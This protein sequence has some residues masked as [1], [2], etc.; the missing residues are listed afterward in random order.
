MSVETEPL[1]MPVDGR[2]ITTV[3]LTME[4]EGLPEPVTWDSELE[5]LRDRGEWGVEWDLS[6][7]HPELRPTWQFDVVASSKERQP[8][9]AADGTPIASSDGSI[10]FGFQPALVDNDSDVIDA[11]DEAIP[12]SE[13]AAERELSR[14]DLNDD[15]FYP[16]ITVS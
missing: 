6:T 4:V 10:T 16:V 7:I 12:G 13:A 2:A 11:F 3:T 9:L 1:N 5:L 8:I 15:W 14:D